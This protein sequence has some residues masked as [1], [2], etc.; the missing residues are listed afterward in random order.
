M[1]KVVKNIKKKTFFKETLI[2]KQKN[3]LQEIKYNKK[4]HI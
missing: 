4:K 3:T 2:S 1:K